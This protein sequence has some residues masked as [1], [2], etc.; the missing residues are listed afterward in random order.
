MP[1]LK[2]N[3]KL[4]G[5]SSREGTEECKNI[6]LRFI[7][8]CRFMASSPD[9]MASNLDDDHCEHLREMYKE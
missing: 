6:Q 5:V 9:T 2:I 1:K 3:V 8:S 4:A 7:G